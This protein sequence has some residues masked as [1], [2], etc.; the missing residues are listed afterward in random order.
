MHKVIYSVLTSAK[1]AP[2]ELI[3]TYANTPGGAGIIKCTAFQYH[4]I[5]SRGYEIPERKTRPTEKK[6]IIGIGLSESVYT[7]EHVIPKKLDAI[8][9]GN[10]SKIISSLLPMSGMLKM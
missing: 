8:K 6:A 9:N 1:D 2:M 7:S 3:F 5:S 4:G 10:N